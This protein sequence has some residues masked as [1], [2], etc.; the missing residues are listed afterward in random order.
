LLGSD[1]A[2]FIVGRLLGALF[3]MFSVST[4]VFFVVR[5]VPGD[6]VESILGEHATAADR[7]ALAEC[8]RLDQSLAA[9]Y[10]HFL[11]D[12]ADGTLGRLCDDPTV[13]VRARLLAVLPFTA[14]LALTSVLLGIVIAVPLG[15]LAAIRRGTWLDLTALFLALVGVS[16]PTFWLGPMLLLLFAVSL[17]AFPD[18]GSGVVGLMALVLPALTLG[19]A[20]S[21]KLARMTRASMLEVL[22]SDYVRTAR[23]K[24]LGER[25]VLFKH[26]LRNAMLPLVTVVGLQIGALLTGTIIVEKVFARP[27]LGS[28]LIDAIE[29]RNYMLVQGCVLV[30]SFTYVLV[31]LLTDLTYVRVDPRIRLSGRPT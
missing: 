14:E 30:I 23:A 15:V 11:G 20:L 8:L 18:P 25:V 10:V 29:Q 26:A 22:G 12:L 3:V 9:Q 21:A 28:L 2:A 5:W 16:I 19:T 4:L 6:P 13:T 7:A 17:R 24:G 27:G 1:R 31:N